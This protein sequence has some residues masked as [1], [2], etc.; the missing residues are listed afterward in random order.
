MDI[1]WIVTYPAAVAKQAAGV[2]L[3][4]AVI[5]VIYYFSPRPIR[6]LLATVITVVVV[7]VSYRI[8][9][10]DMALRDIVGSFLWP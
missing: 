4:V 8:A 1:H 10:G 6:W 9:T 2:L 3:G 7:A 5:M